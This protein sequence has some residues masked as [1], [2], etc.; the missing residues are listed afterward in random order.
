MTENEKAATFIGWAENKLCND[1]R[2]PQRLH[3]F[4]P[5]VIPLLRGE[6]RQHYMDCPEMADPRNYMKA[7]RTYYDQAPNEDEKERRYFEIEAAWGCALQKGDGMLI[8]YLAAL[9]DA[10]H[11][12]QAGAEP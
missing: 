11:A 3:F 8:P 4:G 10:E 5:D 12:T 7:L 9:Y 1:C 6:H 2:D